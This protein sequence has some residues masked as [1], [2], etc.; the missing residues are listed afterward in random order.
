MRIRALLL[1][2][3]ED[4]ILTECV[5]AARSWADEIY[6]FDTGSTDNTL[7]TIKALSSTF[8][9]VHLFR[10][11]Y[12]DFDWWRTANEVFRELFDQADLGDWWCVH[13]TDEIYIE[14]PK[15]I[16]SKAG[17]I[18]RTV[19]CL[20]LNYYFTERELRAY[21]EIAS[22][23]PRTADKQLFSNTLR[24][25]IGNYSEPRF[26]K[27]FDGI[28]KDI[29][30]NSPLFSINARERILMKHLQY[31]S[32]EQIVR[33]VKSRAQIFHGGGKMQFMHEVDF[34]ISDTG[35]FE[36]SL[37]KAVLQPKKIPDS[38]R[39]SDSILLSRVLRSD[40]CQVDEHTGFY[41]IR[42]EHL[43]IIPLGFRLLVCEIRDQIF[44]RLNT[45]VLRV[46]ARLLKL[47]K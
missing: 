9:N 24:H 4:D 2:N 39:S 15:H 43:P 26:F 34:V 42:Y 8:E 46:R 16:I 5:V 22:E 18:P 25:Y 32:P 31:R 21:E 14:N 17:P 30:F 20:T 23:S 10:S 45:Y 35:K 7:E 33:R 6:I 11:E 41:T 1:T 37:W 13:S 27:H 44:I 38:D 3:N 19:W 28:Y 47:L 29:K 36:G 40:Q 12:R